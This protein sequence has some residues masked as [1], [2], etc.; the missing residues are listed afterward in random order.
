LE[1]YVQYRA[2]ARNVGFDKV[3]GLG[4]GQVFIS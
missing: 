3:P 4:F 2:G 1:R